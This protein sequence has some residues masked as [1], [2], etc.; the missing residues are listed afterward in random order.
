LAVADDLVPICGMSALKGFEICN[1]RRGR[2]RGGGVD[3]LLRLFGRIPFELALRIAAVE[4]DSIAAI[5]VKST[6]TL[7][8]PSVIRQRRFG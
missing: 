3:L 7:I 6:W 8:D 5:T 2:L 4:N 1:Q